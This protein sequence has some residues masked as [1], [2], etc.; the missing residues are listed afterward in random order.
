M[1]AA[2]LIAIAPAP[3]LAQRQVTAEEA[4]A[5]YRKMFKSTG[6]IECP[7]DAAEIV[8]CAQRDAADP[9]RLPLPQ[10]PEPGGRIAGHL[11]NGR[12]AMSAERCISRCHQP[13]RVNV[14]AIP[15][16]IGKVIERL[17]DE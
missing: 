4:L 8:V 1:T 6:E 5:N 15:G 13:L 9:N 11:P 12:D 3:A 7:K 17:K 2:L 10:D 16:F 14:L